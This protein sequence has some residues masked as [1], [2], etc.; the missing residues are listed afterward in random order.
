MRL[1]RGRKGQST[2]EYL[3]ILAVIITVIVVVATG[4]FKTNIASLFRRAATKPSNMIT[5]AMLPADPGEPD[6]E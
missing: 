5:E 2:L 1:L 4:A 3:I 6:D